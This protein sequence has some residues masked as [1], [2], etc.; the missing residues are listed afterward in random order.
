MLVAVARDAAKRPTMHRTAP[1]QD[2][3]IQSKM[4]RLLK[5]RNFGALL[6]G[7]LLAMLLINMRNFLQKSTRKAK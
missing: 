1:L 4:L 3:I 5:A 7:I 6:K 2:R